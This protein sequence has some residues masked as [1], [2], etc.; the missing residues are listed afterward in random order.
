MGA[1]GGSSPS[2]VAERAGAIRE[3]ATQPMIELCRALGYCVGVLV[4]LDVSADAFPKIGRRA[5]P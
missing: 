3:S 5:E 4:P 2:A 1:I